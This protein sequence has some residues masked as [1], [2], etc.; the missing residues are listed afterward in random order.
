M[1]SIIARMDTIGLKINKR[2]GKVDIYVNDE[3]LLKIVKKIESKHLKWW[4]SK[5]LRAG[6]YVGLPPE[7]VFYPS[8]RFLIE[9]NKD[10]D[11]WE[12]KIVIYQCHCGHEGCWPL[13][14]KIQ[15]K[16]KEVTWS[17]FE[18]PH[19]GEWKYDLKFTFDKKQ[20]EA[21]IKKKI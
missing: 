6:A 17:D 5:D 4:Q 18:Q 14:V 16:L 13:L 19:R 21:E 15:I 12:D 1:F 20:Y 3:N 10:I 11:D 2:T 7:A 9:P 8:T